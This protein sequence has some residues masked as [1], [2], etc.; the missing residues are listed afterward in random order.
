MFS[1]ERRSDSCFSVWPSRFRHAW[2]Q[3]WNYSCY[4]AKV[5][6]K[7]ALELVAPDGARQSVA[8][9]PNLL[10]TDCSDQPQGLGACVAPIVREGAGWTYPLTDGTATARWV[11]DAPAR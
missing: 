3:A 4:E 9:G 6:G 8:T 10:K 5:S 1:D 11:I 2:E 7:S